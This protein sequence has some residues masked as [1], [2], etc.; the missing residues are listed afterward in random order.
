MSDLSDKG[1]KNEIRA[2]VGE[3]APDFELLT[4]T[5]EKWRLSEHIGNV[6]TL[7]FYPKDE[8]LVCRRQLCSVRDNWRE[9]LRTKAL[10]VGVSPGTIEEHRIFSRR[11][12]FPLP[13][14]ADV[15]RKVTEAYGFHWLFPTFLMRAIV[16]I[17]AKGVIRSRNV[18]LRAFRPSDRSVIASIYAARAD[19]L[20]EKYNSLTGK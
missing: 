4:E 12:E 2:T 19:S 7:L 14:L 18:M 15:D 3:K 16:V 6:I 17:D 13:L 20:A 1:W 10:V 9:Y 11:H 5:G 8:T